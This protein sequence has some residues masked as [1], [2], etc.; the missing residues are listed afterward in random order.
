MIRLTH[1]HYSVSNLTA[2]ETTRNNSPSNQGGKSLTPKYLSG[3]PLKVMTRAFTLKPVSIDY[4]ALTL[5]LRCLIYTQY[6]LY[7]KI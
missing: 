7:F 3:F 4:A 1:I 6:E 5:I 2:D